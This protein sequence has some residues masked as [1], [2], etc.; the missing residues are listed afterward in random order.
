MQIDF[1]HTTTYVAARLAGFEQPQAEIIAYCAQYVDNATSSG[2]I[3]FD[4]QAVYNRISSAHKMLDIRNTKPLANHQV[5][6][7]FHFLPGN[8]GLPASED[9]TGKF[10]NKIVCRADSPVAQDMLRHVIN[11]QD[12]AYSLH[13]LG[14]AMHVYADSWAHQGFAGVMHPVNEVEDATETGNSNVFGNSLRSFLYDVLDNAIPPLGHGRAATF[15]DMP[16]LSWTYLN[17]KGESVSR[18]NTDDFCKAADQMCRAMQRYRAKDADANVPGIGNTDMGRIRNLFSEFKER[19]G[20]KR[21]QQWLQVI[22]DG[23]FSFGAESV[24]YAARGKNSWK[25]HAL[26]TSHDLPVH[27]YHENFLKSNW[28][29]FHDAV[30]SHRFHVVHDILPKYGICAA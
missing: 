16:F 2:T 17:G 10:I 30:Q 12:Q 27:H 29:L 3:F 18:N 4:N 8:A 13:Q 7:T 26:G 21:H 11:Q 22:R 9:Y 20:D 19:E 14:V 23:E 25:A 5:W 1:H 28:K 24:S 6:L 15:P